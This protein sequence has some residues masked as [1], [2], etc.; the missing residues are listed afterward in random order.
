MSDP[1][2]NGLRLDRPADHVC[3]VTID[4]P[5]VN[6]FTP[7][8]YET[9]ARL[10]G[11]LDRDTRTHAVVLTGAGARAFSA[12]TDRASLSLRGTELDA[13]IASAGQ[14]FSRLGEMRTPLIAALN[15][16]AI[17]GGAMIAADCDVLL[18]APE[19]YLAMPELSLGYPGGGSHLMTLVPRFLALR[20][21]L[22]G[23]RLSAERAS[24]YGILRV[25]PA[26]AL[27]REAIECACSIADLD[28]EAVAEARSI[29]RAREDSRAIEGYAAEMRV[30]KSLMT[31]QSCS[32]E[33]DDENVH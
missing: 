6:A 9:A 17:G 28:P 32:E 25:V 3:V 4:L 12:G 7:E 14:L 13:A 15:G 11:D 16:P 24:A 22:L 20:M 27:L 23:E 21:L 26:R 33:S 29:I 8:A 10:L 19:T 31:R 2:A 1:S 18:A 5:P 30:M